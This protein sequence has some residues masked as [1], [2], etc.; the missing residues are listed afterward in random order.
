[1]LDRGVLS[2]EVGTSANIKMAF[3]AVGVSTASFNQVSKVNPCC[4]ADRNVR[5]ASASRVTRQA[6]LP[7]NPRNP[8]EPLSAG[9]PT[10]GG[11][12]SVRSARY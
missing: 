4:V 7:P 6:R 1:M 12:S 9:M 3:H 8:A 2:I 11:V 5:K 10:C